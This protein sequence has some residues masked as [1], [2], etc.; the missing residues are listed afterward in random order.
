MHEE[1]NENILD[2]SIFWHIHK[3]YVKYGCQINFMQGSMSSE[4][5]PILIKNK[6]LYH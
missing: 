1:Y 5:L 2:D 6:N 4:F 3:R